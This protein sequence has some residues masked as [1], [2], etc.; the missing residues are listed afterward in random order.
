MANEITITFGIT[1]NKPSVMSS[2]FARALTGVLRNMG[3]NF[4]VYDTISIPTSVT[5]IPLGS[6][7]QPHWALFM[8]M[9]PT[10]YIQLQVGAGGAPWARML[11]GTA[12]YGDFALVPLEPSSLP[13]AIANTAACQMEYAIGSL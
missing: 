1:F 7:T 6:V 5:A 3:G 2:A 10:N 4:I 9:D 12:P 8:N 13:Y 11:G